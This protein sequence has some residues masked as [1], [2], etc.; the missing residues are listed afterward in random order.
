M[1]IAEQ[2]F[3]SLR[4][5][6]DCRKH[7]T[8]VSSERRIHFIAT[9]NRRRNMITTKQDTG[10]YY[11]SGTINGNFVQYSLMKTFSGLW[12]LTKTYGSGPDYSVTFRTKRS[13]IA[14]LQD[15]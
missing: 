10:F 1:S 8:S 11:V 4:F 2:T 13:A 5:G 15:A 6:R 9:R 14:A 7:W 12:V 3:M